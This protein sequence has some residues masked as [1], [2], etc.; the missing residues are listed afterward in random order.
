MAEATKKTL[1]EGLKKASEKTRERA[2]EKSKSGNSSTNQSAE[3]IRRRAERIA[4]EILEIDAKERGEVI[5]QFVVDY[6][7]NRIAELRE[8]IRRTAG[9]SVPT[10]SEV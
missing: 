9:N 10:I 4:T 8:E 6:V 2:I 1:T 7:E 5:Y 3:E